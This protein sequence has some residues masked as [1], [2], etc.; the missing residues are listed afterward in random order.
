[1]ADLRECSVVNKEKNYK[2]Y[3]KH[4]YNIWKMIEE[5]SNQYPLRPCDPDPKVQERYEKISKL[6]LEAKEKE[7]RER[8][9][10]MGFELKDTEMKENE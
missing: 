8:F 3:K 2:L 10:E 1:M 7:I 4:K 6:F 9:I 5:T